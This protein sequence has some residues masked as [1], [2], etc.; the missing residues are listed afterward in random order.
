M[1]VY[2]YIQGWYQQ[3][4]YVEVTYVL[5]RDRS[6]NALIS[7]EQAFVSSD[8]QFSTL[9]HDGTVPVRQGEVTYRSCL[10][11]KLW[12]IRRQATSG[13]AKVISLFQFAEARDAG[14]P[15]AVDRAELDA[16]SKVPS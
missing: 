13:R 5:V 2:I 7:L 6:S 11:D 3:L 8:I 1:M 16:S 15:R 9:E 10:F 4:P 12:H 14:M